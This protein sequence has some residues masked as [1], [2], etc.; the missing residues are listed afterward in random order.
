MVLQ[1]F[2]VESGPGRRQPGR[3]TGSKC[4][5]F[6]MEIIKNISIVVITAMLTFFT[7]NISN[8]STG[9]IHSTTP[10]GFIKK[11]KSSL[12]NNLKHHG[13]SPLVSDGTYAPTYMPTVRVTMSEDE[14]HNMTQYIN[15]RIHSN[16]V[17]IF[18]KSYCKYSKA[19][20]KLI[21]GIMKNMQQLPPELIIDVDLLKN[22]SSIQEGLTRM[23]G[24]TTV[25]LQFLGGNVDVQELAEKGELQQL[26][27]SISSHA[28]ENAEE[29]GGGGR[30]I[31][32]RKPK[33]VV[34]E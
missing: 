3:A 6:G 20:K 8:I 33:H 22:E 30:R 28:D 14:Y 31:L 26:I 16:G 23:T 2:D 34:V 15:S 1:S 11:Q 9:E 18:A 29:E 10:G 7:L 17:V 5:Q 21:R 27:S 13:S 4:V 32:R 19:A 24:Q 12:N 25:P